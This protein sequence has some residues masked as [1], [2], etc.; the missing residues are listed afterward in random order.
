M[1]S[2]SRSTEKMARQGFSLLLQL[3][4]RQDAR[5]S[6]SKALAFL[7]ILAR[8]KEVTAAPLMLSI[9]MLEL[10]KP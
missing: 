2:T 8:E 3:R 6:L 7:E 1:T 4:E 10:R 9:R 5:Q